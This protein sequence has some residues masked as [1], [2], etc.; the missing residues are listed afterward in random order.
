[1]VLTD[2]FIKVIAGRC[3]EVRVRRSDV[4]QRIEFDNGLSAIDCLDLALGQRIL[5]DLRS[6]VCRKFHHADQLTRPVKYRVVG[7]VDPQL[8]AA[9]GNALEHIRLAFARRE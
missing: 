6:H 5:R 7:R 4:A 1:V 8:I 3:E 2:N 9:L